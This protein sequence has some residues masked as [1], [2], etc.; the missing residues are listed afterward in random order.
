MKYQRTS[1]L[2]GGTEN[3]MSFRK[4]NKQAE[5]DDV[6]V[7]HAK[8]SKGEQQQSAKDQSSEQA[9]AQT[10]GQQA[11]QESGQPPAQAEEAQEAQADEQSTPDDEED[12]ESSA[13]AEPVPDG[14]TAEIL[15]WV[16]DDKKRAQAALD[17]EQAD[18]RPRHG[19]TGELKKILE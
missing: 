13:P 16:G 5:G 10:T 8:G 9:A 2:P 4:K 18:D 3:I 19:L 14:T 17:K 1:Q 12:D 6:K 11:G 7:V 15:R